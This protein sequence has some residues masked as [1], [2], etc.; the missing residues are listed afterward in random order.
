[1]ISK[2]VVKIPEHKINDYSIIIGDDLQQKLLPYLKNKR[3]IIITDSRVKELYA[4]KLKNFLDK[5]AFECNIITFKPG[6]KSKTQVTKTAIEKKMLNLSCDR[7]TMIIALGGG[8]VGDM[9]GFIAATYMRGISYINIPTTLLAMVDSSVGGKTAIDTKQGKNLIGAFWQPSAV[10]VDLDYLK[11]LPKN[12][13]KNG[14]VE[15]IKIFL[16]ADVKYFNYL[17]KNINKILSEDKTILQKII[18]RAIKLKAEIVSKDI[19]D[20]HTRMKLNFGH[21]IGHAIEHASHYKLLHGYAVGLGIL[22]EC[23]I[24]IMHGLLSREDYARIENILMLLDIT[25][26]LLKNIKVKSI[27]KSMQLD[28]KSVDHQSR[29]VLLKKV[30][31]VSIENKMITHTVK[32]QVIKQAILEFMET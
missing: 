18:T 23:R 6:E 5:N 29:F 25:N 20:N 1:M 7:N 26:K 30:G 17:E 28:K 9:A 21:T 10:L 27:M 19:K 8:V 31:Q 2:L 24:A 3:I 14:L 32:D 11:T 15:A 4:N 22:I 13:Y 12:H 16:I